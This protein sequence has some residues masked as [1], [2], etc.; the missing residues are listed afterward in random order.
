MQ[1]SVGTFQPNIL[2]NNDLKWIVCMFM[3]TF[4]TRFSNQLKMKW[5][6]HEKT[7]RLIYLNFIYWVDSQ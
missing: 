2:A 3:S 6:N 1:I 7:V 4:N 5:G